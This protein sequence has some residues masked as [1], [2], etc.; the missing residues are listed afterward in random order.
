MGLILR[1][2]LSK[3]IGLL[4]I[5]RHLYIHTEK[6][7]IHFDPECSQYD[8]RLGYRLKPGQCFFENQEYRTFYRINSLGLRDDESSLHKP[9]IVVLGDSFAMGWGVEQDETFASIIEKKRHSKV[10]N[11]G[12][13]SY[14]TAR[15]MR[16]L[17]QIDRR[18]L[19]YV[20]L[21]YCLN[22]FRENE[23]FHEEGLAF[24]TMSLQKYEETR[25][26]YMDKRT[27]FFG[28][29]FLTLI[30]NFSKSFIKNLHQKNEQLNEADAF[31]YVLSQN[32]QLL[33]NVQL[34]LL[35]LNP[36]GMLRRTF[37]DEVKKK[38]I[39]GYS[40]ATKNMIF[41]DNVDLTADHFFLLDDHINS[42]GH[43]LIARRILEHIE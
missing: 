42:S 35:E 41:I 2:S 3:R 4:G 20:V 13:A 6:K 19:K 9:Q 11:A 7:L 31:L 32:K 22:D 27:Y 24:K 25:L 37:I 28:N 18:A 33:Q 21:Q 40:D 15:A 29:Y 17:D 36:F 43:D 14:G 16:L 5:A 10:L 26:V 23:F 39:T 38:V 8:A 12:I 34:I 30:K 1:P